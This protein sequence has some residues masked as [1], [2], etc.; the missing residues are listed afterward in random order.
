MSERAATI[1]SMYGFQTGK[2][3]EVTHECRK[4]DE[5]SDKAACAMC[6]AMTHNKVEPVWLDHRDL[7][8]VSEVQAAVTEL[9][10]ELMADDFDSFTCPF[11]ETD[12]CRSL[13]RLGRPH[14]KK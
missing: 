4:F 11:P 8:D 2:L 7:K 5:R 14:S 6:Q 3:P 12:R 1:G 9:F 10:M 13:R